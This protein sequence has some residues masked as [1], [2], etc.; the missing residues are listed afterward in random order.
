MSI[1]AEP[2]EDEIGCCFDIDADSV[3]EIGA[4]AE[5][6]I[7]AVAEVEIETE[8]LEDDYTA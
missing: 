1:G 6:E 2:S 8:T 7:G 3:F 4:V 5:V